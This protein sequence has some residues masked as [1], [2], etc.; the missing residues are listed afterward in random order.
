LFE[1]RRRELIRKERGKTWTGWAWNGITSVFGGKEEEDMTPGEKVRTPGGTPV[2]TP[3]SGTPAPAP[4]PGSPGLGAI[5]GLKELGDGSIGRSGSGRGRGRM[6]PSVG[7][8]ESGIMLEE[9]LGRRE[10]S[11]DRW[12]AAGGV[13]RGRGRGVET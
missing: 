12:D 4:R 8:R 6:R 11:V 7:R 5:G 2:S 13:G 3:R 9:R 1:K 10:R